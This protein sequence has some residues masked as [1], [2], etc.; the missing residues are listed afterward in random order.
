MTV[1][2]LLTIDGVMAAV[3]VTLLNVALLV[4]A[5]PASPPD[6]L[7]PPRPRT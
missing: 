2:V 7:R 6:P 3:L 4:G 1:G 5:R